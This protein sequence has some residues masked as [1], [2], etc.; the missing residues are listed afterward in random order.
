[1]TQ[2]DV[3]KPAETSARKPMASSNP[4]M[5]SRP[6]KPGETYG[7]PGQGESLLISAISGW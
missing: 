5:R 6:T 3:S 7:V 4:L 2:L 1:M